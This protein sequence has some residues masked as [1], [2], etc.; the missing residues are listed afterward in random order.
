MRIVFFAVSE[1]KGAVTVTGTFH[2]EL[3]DY[4][5]VLGS[6]S[7][8]I[9]AWKDGKDACREFG[10]THPI[11]RMEG[12]QI[13]DA[14]LALGVYSLGPSA[15]ASKRLGGTNGIIRVGSTPVSA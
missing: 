5:A 12:T 2:V 1:T 10:C 7:T 14:P 3:G 6:S 8:A 9:H 4:V 13:P 11:T 15:P